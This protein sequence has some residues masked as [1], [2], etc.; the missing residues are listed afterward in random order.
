MYVR[1][2]FAWDD[3]EVR[4]EG[5]Q[6]TLTGYAAVFNR[7]SEDLGGFREKIQ[8][9]AFAKTIREGD[10]MALF[11]HDPKLVLGRTKNNTLSLSEDEHGLYVSIKPPDTLLGRDVTALIQGKYIDQMSFGFQVNRD[12]GQKVEIDSKGTFIQTLKEVRLRDV[13]P[14]TFPAYTQTNISAR[15]QQ[16]G[17][18]FEQLGSGEDI[19]EL[20][21]LLLRNSLDELQKRIGVSAPADNSHPDNGAPADNIHPSESVEVFR[22]RLEA[23]NRRLR[24]AEAA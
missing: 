19:G 15:S 14:V 6:R 2:T 4:Q 12:S 17:N 20:E 22:R 7:L 1:R 11:N 23:I 24:I 9:G 18:I 10:V 16:L 3:I 8:P 5:E 21:M 13:S